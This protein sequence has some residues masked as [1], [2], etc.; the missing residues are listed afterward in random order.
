MDRIF[1][2]RLDAKNPITITDQGFMKVDALV[3]RAGVFDYYKKDGGVSRELRTP[4]EVFNSDSLESLKGIPIT[5][6]NPEGKLKH[7]TEKVDSVN[8][9]KY[10]VGVTGEDVKRVDQNGIPFVSVNMTIMDF[11]VVKHIEAKRLDGEDVSLSCGYGTKVVPESGTHDTEGHYDA[12]QVGIH[13]N[14]V[15]IVE[16]GRA[17]EDVKLRLDEKHETEIN[18]SKSKED[19]KKMANFTKNAIKTDSFH[20]DAVNVEIDDKAIPTMNAMSAKVD[21]AVEA[22]AT[23]ESKTD[24]A[25]KANEELTTKQDALTKEVEGLKKDNEELSNLDSPR[26]QKMISSRADMEVVA[27]ALKIEHTDSEGVKVPRKDLRDKIL[28]ANTNDSES[29]KDKTDEYKDARY[30]AIEDSIKKQKKDAEGIPDKSLGAFNV[31]VAVKKL[32]G[33]EEKKDAATNFKDKTENLHLAD[34][35]N[36]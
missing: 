22:I 11:D 20:M 9:K 16:S 6:L 12:K 13:Y 19:L 18:K 25:T 28:A 32:D 30:D 31:G 35:D 7:P 27:D 15:S 1:N 34:R 24:E 26:I 3:T 5:F 2:F 8:F 36:K 21:E 33:S 4:E 17:G 23:A 29:L 14:H 10:T